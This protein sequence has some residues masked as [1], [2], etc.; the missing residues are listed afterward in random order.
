MHKEIG[1][2]NEKM[3]A[4][5]DPHESLLSGRQ[6]YF[7]NITLDAAPLSPRQIASDDQRRPSLHGGAPKPNFFRPPVPS[8]L[9]STPRR[10]GSIGAPNSPS[11][12]LRPT[13]PPPHPPSQHPLASASSPPGPNIARRHTSADI[14]LPGW[15][16]HGAASPLASGQS[17]GHWP[18]SP[19]QTPSHG[20][21]HV[22]DVLAQYEMGGS[23]ASY[24]SRQPTPP[25]TS[26]TTPS[27]LSAESGWS[28]GP[29][30]FP[31]KSLDIS[32]PATR[33]SSM[34]SNVHSLLNPAET[35][36]RVDTDEATGED[37]KRKRMQ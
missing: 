21:Q 3:R 13:A 26:D 5:E 29:S 9:T 35:A 1:R 12:Y 23:R 28:F 27:T 19:N 22:R 6:P 33:R 14:R 15:P 4:L 2:Q 18:S 30:K 11:N 37:R 20:D 10:Y 7:S 25:L 32:A 24:A 16:G 31:T 8:H 36:E 34:A 17:S